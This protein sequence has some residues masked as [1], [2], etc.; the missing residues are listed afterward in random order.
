VIAQ[1]DTRRQDAQVA[2]DE[3]SVARATADLERLKAAQSQAVAEVQRVHA[4]GDQA[5]AD[6]ARAQAL[7]TQAA[8]DLTRAKSLADAQLTSPADLD[9]SVANQAALEAQLDAAQAAVQLNTAQIASAEAALEQATAE[10]SVGQASIRQN[11]AQLQ[12]DRVNLDFARIV[13]PVDGVVVSRNVDV[14]QTVAASL[15]APTL[16]VIANDLTK[17][18]VQT[19]V[20]EAD[21]GKLHEGQRAR[22][23]VDAHAERGFEGSVSQLRLAATTVQNVVTYTVLVDASNP[24]G[25]LLPGMTANVTFEIERSTKDALHV[26]ASALRLQPPAELLAP[27][28]RSSA[29]MMEQPPAPKLAHEERP[30]RGASGKGVKSK[31]SVVYVETPD[32]HLAAIPVKQGISDGIRTVIEPLD[33]TALLEGSEVVTAVL[34]SDQPAATNPFGPPSIG[35]PRGSGLAR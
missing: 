30:G 20:P 22:F 31:G 26:A 27:E 7:Q 23:T 34:A 28:V 32:H 3:A 16:F 15:Q 33:A 9:A 29:G 13:S 1:L 5:T 25:L 19:S 14:G 24:D 21:I 18:Q 2:Q 17:V 6:V 12:G 10:I 4:A 35:A 11:Q 8:H